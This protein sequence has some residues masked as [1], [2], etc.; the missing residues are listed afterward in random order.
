MASKLGG[1]LW[2]EF[3][4]SAA[5]A[6]GETLAQKLGEH[7]WGMLQDWRNH[8]AAQPAPNVSAM[9][10]KSYLENSAFAQFNRSNVVAWAL[11]K[12]AHLP[13]GQ[14]EQVIRVTAQNANGDVTRTVDGIIRYFAAA[15]FGYR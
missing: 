3:A 6:L 8:T 12:L 15:D 13:A 1:K 11:W 9:A 14:A 5:G 2:E 4:V 10:V 7:A